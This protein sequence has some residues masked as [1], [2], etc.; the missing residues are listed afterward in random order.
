[1]PAKKHILSY[2]IIAEIILG[3]IVLV[4]IGFGALAYILSQG[5]INLE[6]AIPYIQSQINQSSDTIDI[7]IGQMELEWQ[8]FE[9]PLGLSAKDVVISNPRGPFLFSPEI[10]MNIS[11]RSLV[12][13]RLKIET[14]WVRRVA[15]SVT[16]TKEGEI[17][18]TGQEIDQESRVNDNI[19]PALPTLNNLIHDLPRMDRL[20]IDKASIIYRDMADDK[21]SVF[22]PVTFFVEMGDVSDE[23]NLSGFVTFPFGDNAQDNVARL[24]FSTTSNPVLLNVNG[25]LQET[26]IDSFTQFTPSLPDGFDLNMVVNSNFQIQ[27]DNLWNLHQADIDIKADRGQ[28]HFPLNDKEDHIDVSNVH[29]HAVHDPKTNLT[30]F[31]NFKV[32]I[33]DQVDIS[34]MGDVKNIEKPDQLSGDITLTINNLPQSYF[35]KYW[36]TE[37][38]D[39]GAYR[40]LAEKM[41]GGT[42]QS[43]SLNTV[44]DLSAKD[45]DDGSPLPPQIKDIKGTMSYDNLTINYNDPMPKATKVNGTGTYDNIELTLNVD[46][47]MIGTMKTTDATLYFDDLITKGSGLGTLKF[48]VQAQAQDVFDYIAGEPINA[49]KN[50]DFKPR[51]TKGNVDAVVDIE[52]PLLKDVLI[53][54]VM[55]TVNGTVNNAE[56]PNAVRGL[57]LAGG[58]YTIF[59]TTEQIKVNGS[60]QLQGKP[61]TLDWHE[62]FSAKSSTED[63]Q[64]KITATVEANDAIRRAF[65]NDF[66]DYFR[67]D[68]DVQATYVTS[69][70]GRDADIDLNLNLNQTAV[71][72]PEFGLD[73]KFGQSGK[74]S[75]SVDLINGQ[76]KSIRNLKIEGPGLSI[77]NGTLDFKPVKDPE[78]I[79]ADLKNIAFDDNRFSVKIADQGQIRK[80]NLTGAYLN[81]EPFLGGKKKDKQQSSNDTTSTPM[82]IGIDVLEMGVSDALPLRNPKAY[83]RLDRFD[84]VERF[85]MDANVGAKSAK[86]DLF[87]RYTPDVEDGLT[88]RV[89]S[90][91][92]GETLRAFGL[93][94]YIQ[95]GELQIAGTPIDG[96]RF[97]DVRG[98]ARINN[99]TVSNAPVLLRLI[100][101]LSFQ[102]FL[103]AGQLGFARLE[104]DFEWLVRDEGDIYTITDG[105][106]SGASVALTFDGVVN[107]ED[108]KINMKGTAAP[109]SEVN[110]FIG[111]IP[112]IGD[113]LTGG[114]AL[115]AA[116][117]TIKGPIDDPIVAINPLS[118][119]APGIIRKMLFEGSAPT[120]TE[121]ATPP[122]RERGQ[123][124]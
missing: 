111:N 106:T 70:N 67:G 29:I 86:G 76:L 107:T 2:K 112:I 21:T 34:A 43:V 35:P 10:D 103:Q 40:W 19:A 28:V 49:F 47:A 93:Y 75:L 100:N 116:T 45:R 6:K 37:L 89:E 73:K 55:V 23:R 104:S 54:D 8:G 79:S 27:L 52:I 66:A 50:V 44:F 68:T 99:F 1:M 30:S 32:N 13:G 57:T 82:E 65:T 48:P 108:D 53:E 74:A 120:K 94:P 25:A 81:I 15:L 22:D 60:G 101:A 3:F 63:Y 69:K 16:K 18:L 105:R 85:E 123:L 72:A 88:L 62:F 96:G 122:P 5:P 33:N 77:A 124:N 110:T 64:S 97:G 115:L 90:N 117:Y 4:M 36:P 20:W 12:A 78:L 11:L 95:G 51:D 9:N 102:N 56:I 38:S 109:L 80:I 71:T 119:L 83:I 58:P 42:F 118:V 39:N 91:N 46:D 26:P 84:Q 24:N 92:A 121:E 98:K 59:A 17:T 87:V 41:E 31:K 114:G 14:L 113:I 61:I 7:E